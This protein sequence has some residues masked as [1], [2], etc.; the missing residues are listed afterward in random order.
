MQKERIVLVSRFP[1]HINQPKGGVE[2]ATL[3]LAKALLV[4]G[5]NDLHIVTLEH[6]ITETAVE[7]HSNI[8]VHRLPR[9]KWPM[10]LDVFFGPST[11]RLRKYLCQLGPSIVHFHETWGLSAPL[12]GFPTV[13]TVHGFDSLNLP[14]ENAPYSRIRQVLWKYAEKRGLR[15]QTHLISIAPYVHKKIKLHTSAKIFDIWNSVDPLFFAMK[16]EPEKLT[17]L[18]LGWLN[19]R[20][21]PLVIVQAAAS[22]MEKYPDLKIELCGGAPS[23]SYKQTLL[24][25]IE[26]LGLQNSVK[27]PGMLSQA[28]VKQQLS[29][30]TLLVLPSFQENAPMVIAEAMALGVPVIASNLCGIPDM[31]QNNK[32]GILLDD[33]TNVLKLSRAIDL[34]LA[35]DKKRHD[36]IDNARIRA[37]KLF[38][39]EA[40]AKATLEVY[41]TAINEYKN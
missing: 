28:D 15:D 35:D 27:M 2:S 26:K 8:T 18:F 19:A 9:S 34:L 31:I 24:M 20:K 1:T 6:G 5:V 41:E 40:V 7:N 11:S 17:I 16:P 30:A 36:I 39:P 21:N 4:A 29:K 25:E 22:L 12:C 13:F 38:H 32:S 37:R 14:A 23:P 33:P 10:V 3:G